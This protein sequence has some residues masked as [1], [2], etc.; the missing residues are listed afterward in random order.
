MGKG[1]QFLLGVVYQLGLNGGVQIGLD[2]VLGGGIAGDGHDGPV[3]AVF[4]QH[5]A[6]D[7]GELLLHPGQLNPDGGRGGISQPAA[8]SGDG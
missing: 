4:H 2:G 6:V 8:G 7:S 3:V 5:L 1:K